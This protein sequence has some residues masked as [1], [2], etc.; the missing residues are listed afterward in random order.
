MTTPH[1][2]NPEDWVTVR[3][4]AEAT[5]NTP[6]AI[7]LALYDKADP[8]PCARRGRAIRVRLADWRDWWAKR[9]TTI[10]PG[11][12]AR[13]PLRRGARQTVYKPRG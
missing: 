6:N 11:S 8:M 1:V 9:T 4:L 3:R 13:A 10:Q 2:L 7:Y 5:G 12:P